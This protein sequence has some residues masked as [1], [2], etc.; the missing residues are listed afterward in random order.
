MKFTVKRSEWLRGEG[1]APSRLFRKTD[2]KRCCLG[3]FANACGFTDDELADNRTVAQM[4]M[5]RRL[6]EL[7]NAA[8]EDSRRRLLGFLLDNRGINSDAAEEL[9]KVN[10]AFDASVWNGSFEQPLDREAK[11]TKL[12][13]DAGHEVVFVD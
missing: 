8:P 10:D 1:G 13:A 9:M 5:E 3:F 4:A 12:F 11:L 6:L 2:N 7:K